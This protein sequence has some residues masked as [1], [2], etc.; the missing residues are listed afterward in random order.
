MLEPGLTLRG[1]GDWKPYPACFRGPVL[2]REPVKVVAENASQLRCADRLDAGKFPCALECALREPP[3]VPLGRRLDVT[4]LLR[5]AICG[6]EEPE[7][8]VPG[9]FCA[10]ELSRAALFAL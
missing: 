4:D 8:P 10:R 6:L 3:P 7:E 1:L 9:L 2:I 5:L